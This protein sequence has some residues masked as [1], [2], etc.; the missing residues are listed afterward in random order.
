MKI[1]PVKTLVLI[2]GDSLNHEGEGTYEGTMVYW[3][4]IDVPPGSLSIPMMVESS[5]ETLSSEYLDWC[6]V[7]AKVRVGK[8]NL[9]TALR[10]DLLSQGSFWWT[11]LV[12]QRSPMVSP[13]IYEV[14]KLRVL[15]KLYAAGGYQ[16]L[17][18]I[19]AG[20]R[21]EGV[22]RQWCKLLG[23]DFHW[24][25]PEQSRLIKG[26]SGRRWTKRLPHPLRALFSLGHFLLTRYI[27]IFGAGKGRAKPLCDAD[28]AIVTYFPNI[29]LA[30]AKAGNFQSNF[31]GPLHGLIKELGLKVNWIWFYSQAP[32]MSYRESVVF[33]RSL[34]RQ[35]KKTGQRHLMLEDR[36]KLTGVLSAIWAYLRLAKTSFRL[37]QCREHFTFP[38]GALN[39]FQFLKDDWYSS[40]RGIA[41]MDTC[42]YAAAF[43]DSVR[44]LPATTTR[45]I[46]TWENQGL[47]LSL[48]HAWRNRF[49]APVLGFIHSYNLTAVMNLRAY[50]DRDPVASPYGRPHPDKLIT[51]G[52]VPSNNLRQ[53][54]WPSHIVTEAEALRYMSLMG[55]YGVERRAVPEIG[56]RLL[57]ITGYMHSE[58]EAQLRLLAAAAKLGGLRAYSQVTIKPHPSTPV[59][60]ILAD[61]L[62]DFTP[63]VT[64][65]PLSEL[66]A[67]AD[68]VFA[69]NSTSAAIEAAWVGLPLILMAAIGEINLS[70]LRGMKGVDF[71]ATAADLEK[72][73]NTPARIELSPDC[74][75]LDPELAKWKKLLHN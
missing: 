58:T 41:A 69:A 54:G 17:C 65:T 45:M 42:L 48:L 27:C 26:S 21:L 47:E 70:A 15:E 25:R 1:D 31:W 61:H 64:N 74:Y 73:L 9:V 36:L 13:M 5:A 10:S 55:K 20:A 32:E 8:E 39:F 53:W 49:K 75:C 11:T 22:L 62:F 28:L 52:R 40:L 16:G 63:R 29:N 38:G 6:A 23:H 18:C 4:R 44:E 14:F 57:V 67:D 12:A 56:R 33:Q 19:G 60:K 59:D 71:V 30:A 35:T 37:K 51:V 2:V 46:Y 3:D 68:V 24:K 50:P 72:Q 7:L 43:R 34:N 66:F